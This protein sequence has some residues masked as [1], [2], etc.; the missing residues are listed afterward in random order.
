MRLAAIERD[1]AIPGKRRINVEACRAEIVMRHEAP[2]PRP[3]LA[4]RLA[5]CTQAMLKPIDFG[6]NRDFAL[7]AGLAEIQASFAGR[8]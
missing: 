2:F 7:A 1:G 4:A 6:L 8:R 5:G 3:F